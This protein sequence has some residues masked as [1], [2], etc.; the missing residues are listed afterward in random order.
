ML[1]LPTRHIAA[2]AANSKQ[3][4]RFDILSNPEFDFLTEGTTV[5]DF[6]TPDRVLIGSRQTPEGKAHASP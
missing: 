2:V 4:L 3:G 1:K 6:F 5:N